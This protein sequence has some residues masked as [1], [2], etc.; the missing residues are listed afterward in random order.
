MAGYDWIYGRSRGAGETSRGSQFGP[1]SSGPRH[2]GHSRY[3]SGLNRYDA[4]IGNGWG[5]HPGESYIENYGSYGITPQEGPPGRGPAGPGER[6]GPGW[7]GRPPGYRGYR[8]REWEMTR[9]YDAGFGRLSQRD[10]F[11]EHPGRGGRRRE[12]G[13]RYDSWRRDWSRG[14]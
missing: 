5:H 13:S 8:R 9:G 4:Q 1:G 14:G 3:G 6:S 12:M 7:G 2:G 11:G 10:P